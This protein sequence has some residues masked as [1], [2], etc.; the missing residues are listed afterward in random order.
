MHLLE[1]TL[2][3]KEVQRLKHNK[4]MQNPEYHTNNY[5]VLNKRGFIHTNTKLQRGKKNQDFKYA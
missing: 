1:S 3:C 4:A 5:Q 2:L